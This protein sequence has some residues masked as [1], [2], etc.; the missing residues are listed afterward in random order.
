[1]SQP[2]AGDPHDGRRG[3]DPSSVG[4]IDVVFLDPAD[5]TRDNDDPAAA[6]LVATFP[7]S[8]V[9]GGAQPGERLAPHDLR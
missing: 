4:D 5:L 3:F 2:S 7:A 8:P 9:G 1:M 6:R